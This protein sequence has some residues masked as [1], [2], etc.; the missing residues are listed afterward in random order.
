MNYFLLGGVGLLSIL[1][2]LIA[3]WLI[4][5]YNFFVYN[6]I[7]VDEKWA[8]IEVALKKKYDMVP[9]IAD[10][11]KG[12]V[13][14]EKGTLS[15][16]TELRSQWGKAKNIPEKLSLSN[17]LDAALG[18]LMAVIEKYPQLK[19]DRHFLDLQRQIRRVENEIGHY[20]KDYNRRVSKY[21]RRIEFFPNNLVA[22]KFGFEKR[23]FYS[24]TSD[25]TSE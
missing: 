22:K 1:I 18:K 5:T 16:V 15:E 6:R 10:T 24:I 19:A 21:N 13:K 9:A 4:K 17:A 2:I 3:N 25:E 12:Y 11:V 14:H 8:Q 7:K 23:A 20:R